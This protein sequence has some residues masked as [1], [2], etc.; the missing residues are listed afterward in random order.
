VAKLIF[1]YNP[2]S[3]E[4]KEYDYD[5]PLLGLLLNQFIRENPEYYNYFAKVGLSIRVNNKEIPPADVCYT[6]ITSSDEI[7]IYPDVEIVAVLIPLLA[8]MAT[9]VGATSFAAG[10]TTSAAGFGTG[11]AAMGGA[12]VAGATA[13][14][15]TGLALQAV[16][17]AM[18]AYAL[19][20][21][22]TMS[23]PSM[24]TGDKSPGES[25]PTYGWG[26]VRSMANDGISKPVIYGKVKVG[27]NKISTT[28]ESHLAFVYD[29][30]NTNDEFCKAIAIG[31][32]PSTTLPIPFLNV[33]LMGLWPPIRGWYCEV[34]PNVW[35]Y[36]FFRMRL[37]SWGDIRRIFVILAELLQLFSFEFLGK[38]IGRGVGKFLMAK[39]MHNI[40][41][42]WQPGSILK[43]I[44][45]WLKNRG[46]NTYHD[47][48][49]D[50]FTN[51]QN[52]LTNDIFGDFSP[53]GM[54]THLHN[55]FDD[56]VGEV[57]PVTGTILSEDHRADIIARITEILQDNKISKGWSVKL[58]VPVRLGKQ[59]E[60]IFDDYPLTQDN[61]GCYLVGCIPVFPDAKVPQW[62]LSDIQGLSTEAEDYELPN[63]IVIQAPTLSQ[64]DEQYLHVL[65]ALGEGEMAGIDRIYLNKNP[66]DIY[67]ATDYA[68][69]PGTNDQQFGGHGTSELGYYNKTVKTSRDYSTKEL[70]KELDD[71]QYICTGECNNVYIHLK[72]NA[73]KMDKKGH[74][75]SLGDKKIR[76][77]IQVNF[78]DADATVWPDPL[79]VNNYLDISSHRCFTTVWTQKGGT[80]A[81]IYKQHAAFPIIDWVAGPIDDWI[82]HIPGGTAVLYS[83][84]GGGDYYI[85]STHYQDGVYYNGSWEFNA[86]AYLNISTGYKA[87]IEAWLKE[88]LNEF[89]LTAS[90]RLAVR[91]IRVSPDYSDKPEITAKM[92]V[93]GFDEVLYTDFNYP[94]TA[95]L[96]VKARATEKLNTSPPDVS[97]VVKG[98][99][100][101]VPK[102]VLFGD[103]ATQVYREQC[104]FDEDINAYRSKMHNGA[105]CIEYN[106]ISAPRQM[107]LEYSSNP[108]WCLYDL[109]TNDRYGLG[110]YI[111]EGDID[112]LQFV[113]MAQYCDQMVPDG[114]LRFAD[115]LMRHVLVDN[116]LDLFKMDS[117]WYDEE[118]NLV[119]EINQKWNNQ[120]VW[121]FKRTLVGE[122][123]FVKNFSR[124]YSNLDAPSNFCWSK[125]IIHDAHRPEYGLPLLGAT[126]TM[127]LLAGAFWN[128]NYWTNGGPGES[129]YI[130]S[131]NQYML[132]Q[133]RHT[134]NIALDDSSPAP[135]IIKTICDTC[136]CWPIWTNGAV[137]PVIDKNENPVA[138]FGMGNIIKDSF[139]L[140][141]GSISEVPNVLECEF[142]NS[143]MI[144]EKDTMMEVDPD[145]DIADAT[146]ITGVE[147]KDSIKLLGITDPVELKRELKY[148]IQFLKNN[149]KTISFKTGVEGYTLT[150][151]DV[152]AFTHD[153]LT[154]SSYSGRVIMYE[155]GIVYVDQDLSS[156]SGTLEIHFKSVV[157]GIE[158]VVPCSVINIDGNKVIV[159][160]PSGFTPE[161]FDN[162]AIGNVDEV[163]ELYRAISVMPNKDG[164]VEVSA[165]LYNEG[166]YGIK[167]PLVGKSDEYSFYD[168]VYLGA[169]KE[170]IPSFPPIVSRQSIQNLTLSV[171]TDMTGI[172]GYF[173]LP[174]DASLKT[175]LKTSFD[176]AI[177]ARSNWARVT[178]VPNPGKRL[179]VSAS[180]LVKGK[181]IFVRG[182]SEFEGGAAVE[183]SGAS[184]WFNA[185]GAIPYIPPGSG[186]NGGDYNYIAVP[187]PSI[188]LS[189][190]CRVN[191]I[192][193]RHFITPFLSIEWEPGGPKYTDGS[194]TE[195]PN[196]SVRSYNVTVRGSVLGEGG[197]LYNSYRVIWTTHVGPYDRRLTVPRLRLITMSGLTTL[198]RY[199]SVWVDVTT[200]LDGGIESAPVSQAFYNGAPAGTLRVDA[201]HILGSCWAFWQPPKDWQDI[202]EWEVFFVLRSSNDKEKYMSNYPD[203]VRLDGGA[204]SC[205]YK[206][207]AVGGET[208]NYAGSGMGPFIPK[209]YPLKVEAYITAIDCFGSRSA[210]LVS[211]P[212]TGVDPQGT[213]DTG[214]DFPWTLTMPISDVH[215]DYNYWQLFESNIKSVIDWALDFDPVKQAQCKAC[216]DG[217]SG[218]YLELDGGM[219]GLWNGFAAWGGVNEL[220]M[221]TVRLNYRH[222]METFFTKLVMNVDYPCRVWVEF[223]NQ[224][225]INDPQLFTYEV[226]AGADNSHAFTDGMTLTQYSA[227]GG[228][229][230][231]LNVITQVK[232]RWVVIPSGSSTLNFPNLLRGKY[233][234]LILRPDT[235]S[236]GQK[237]KIYEMRFSQKVYADELVFNRLEA[238][239]GSFIVDADTNTFWSKAG[240]FG[241][242]YADPIV[243]IS[244]FGI[245]VNP[246]GAP[247]NTYIGIGNDAIDGT[248]GIV[249][250]VNGVK[251]LQISAASGTFW[252]GS[253]GIGGTTD[254]PYIHLEQ[255]GMSVY[256]G[257]ST[258]KVSIGYSAIN[259]NEVGVIGISG[260]TTTFLLD[261]LTGK[262]WSRFGGFGGTV[263][264]PAV[265][266]SQ[267]GL[268]MVSGAR[269]IGIGVSPFDGTVGIEARSLIGALTFSLNAGTGYIWSNYGGFGGSVTTPAVGLYSDGILVV[270][271]A[272]AN[273]I[274][275]G[276]FVH[277]TVP[278]RG[279]AA[280]SGT[281]TTV[282]I[283]ANSGTLW[284]NRGGFGGNPSGS[285][286]SLGGYGFTLRDMIGGSSSVVQIGF[287]FPDFV[288][289][290]HAYSGTTLTTRLNATNGYFWSTVG[291]FGGTSPINCNVG[292]VSGGLTVATAG[293]GRI[294]IGQEVIPLIGNY[295]GITAYNSLGECTFAIS[296]ATGDIWT[297]KG[298]IGGS[299]VG[300]GVIE[301]AHSGLIVK[302]VGGITVVSGADITMMPGSGVDYARLRWPNAGSI[303]ADNSSSPGYALFIAPTTELKWLQVGLGSNRYNTWGWVNINAVNTIIMTATSGLT[304]PSG[305]TFKISNNDILRGF[306]FNSTASGTLLNVNI[307]SGTTVF[308]SQNFK[309]Y[310]NG[311]VWA[312]GAITGGSTGAVTQ[313][314]A[315]SG[316]VLDPSYGTGAVRVHVSGVTGGTGGAVNQV[317]GTGGITVSPTTGNVVVGPVNALYNAPWRA[318]VGYLPMSLSGMLICKDPFNW[319]NPFY[320]FNENE[321]LFHPSSSGYFGM[322]GTE[323]Y[324]DMPVVNI[325]NGSYVRLSAS[326]NTITINPVT[327]LNFNINDAAR[328][329]LTNTA[330]T[331][332]PNINLSGSITSASGAYFEGSVSVGGSLGGGYVNAALNIMAGGYLHC[333]GLYCSG[334]AF[335]RGDIDVQGTITRSG[336]ILYFQDINTGPVSLADLVA[337]G[338]S[339]NISN[340]ATWVSCG[341]GYVDCFIS[342]VGMIKVNSSGMTIS[343][344]INL[345]RSLISTSG[346]YFDGAVSAGGSLGGGYVNAALDITAG[347][348]LHCHGINCSGSIVNSGTNSWLLGT[349]WIGGGG[350]TSIVGFIRVHINGSGAN[351]PIYG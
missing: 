154:L 239:N 338:A 297:R 116:D 5:A 118:G 293:A 55:A 276:N 195:T 235:D 153:I 205:F 160:L 215:M 228:I 261:A 288:M 4:S 127:D 177:D 230:Q 87:S 115:Y 7:V 284:A 59:F 3:K 329:S 95:M 311:D 345:T 37:W 189:D 41:G 18:M 112:F 22:F 275:I 142:S 278:M 287:S 77:A 253:G 224:Y 120:S 289:G 216:F 152:F 193:T 141:Y 172:D 225:D 42:E 280:F 187:P 135:D 89:Y 47:E 26:G 92:Y 234:R 24:S 80:K 269:Y 67:K 16:G 144:Y 133:K 70:V 100:I 126:C 10:L 240:G 259:P 122:P 25:S 266:I 229:G 191:Y 114:T 123:I 43:G 161:N 310:A 333:H 97:A 218:T 102:L 273:R 209:D 166:T 317:T 249:A 158:V 194:I 145:I 48:S 20:K 53:D 180:N 210:T 196:I 226:F 299:T 148:R 207:K 79:D 34:N 212:G 272:Y 128:G 146:D 85:R 1:V 350:G 74:L 315:G 267:A 220:L 164:E 271:G 247:W 90:R 221:P 121:S 264:T 9:A 175:Y 248:W 45:E 324:Y 213:G 165:V 233:I 170:R 303:Y 211:E 63:G 327:T 186:D 156:L 295:N 283:D 200:V 307:P 286:V 137:R 321:V 36:V 349:A 29:W 168:D 66:M 125:A 27:G 346:A 62:W 13:G 76:Y 223:V 58:F 99:K 46:D 227:S 130:N 262:V 341:I 319:I 320:Y 56:L 69:L 91:V 32:I 68:F 50:E 40:L 111:D 343:G 292:I 151:G 147:R 236:A 8:Q 124:D 260:G 155:N 23:K 326:G 106:S 203:S 290:I 334:A 104:W 14:I 328:M 134:L 257:A 279:I 270:S 274:A 162:Y 163:T 322:L 316:I 38:I 49:D 340:G 51:V 347:G 199:K 192:D 44:S 302:G 84:L 176:V 169:I 265:N 190:I 206:F 12:T 150:A 73:F 217:M 178:E 136:R 183:C 57:D 300:S 96:A 314:L 268:G 110:N 86:I 71:E 21:P 330:F 214:N 309:V 33:G 332:I 202:D 219:P 101:W 113:H 98:K 348:S 93:E 242:T 109:L 83:F 140:A 263:D 237:V 232:D 208:R 335:V 181:Q 103:R 241:N 88:K 336:N 298:F 31:L 72:F 231:Y 28:V 188:N 173:N 15:V 35:F 325:K 301:I 159:A 243:K 222:P 331:C 255:H 323:L 52:T 185:S 179:F 119:D 65:T 252:T 312:S 131:E 129:D 285:I 139:S 19:V 254:A 54:G 251:T 184:V 342:N 291:G 11:M 149:N 305:S 60:E 138:I 304:A 198:E 351:I 306:E 250:R 167:R 117:P 201:F 174:P 17:F 277:D 2:I 132:A 30:F 339:T 197:D 75:V 81:D 245:Y 246:S 296:S 108:M 256:S 107:T 282:V 337:G 294:T 182:I 105:P 238:S 244:D 204:R 344:G 61:L 313:L 39:L 94:N 82:V 157:D 281:T 143:D 64:S 78:M 171:R 318:Y 308:N 258:S 6:A